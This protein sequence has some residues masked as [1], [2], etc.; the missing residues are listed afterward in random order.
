MADRFEKYIVENK[1]AFDFKSPPSSVWENIAAGLK[2]PGSTRYLRYWQAAAVVFFAVSIGLLVKNIQPTSATM[3]SESVV[4]FKTT[5]EYYLNVIESQQGILTTYL[6][7]YPDL[8]SDFKMDLTELSQN[9]NKLKI[10]FESTGDTEVLNAL[11]K[12]LQLQQELLQN[13]L[14]I[15]KQIEEENENVSI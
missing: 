5:E 14:N 7:Q 10:D 13:Q 3:V 4:E 2:R 8:A 12:N 1:A 9:Y 15:I 11:I 6:K